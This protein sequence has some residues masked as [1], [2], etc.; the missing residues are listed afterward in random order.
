MTNGRGV[1]LVIDPIGGD[2]WKKSYLALRATGRL[3]M[4]GVST[5]SANGLKG[6]LGLLK[7]AWQT[8][9]FHPFGLMNKNKGVF[10]LNLGHMWDE[11]EKVAEWMKVIFD[12][13]KEGWIRPYVDK[14]FQFDKVAEAHTYIESRKNIG[15]VV[16]VP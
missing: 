7:A 10:G 2:H 11:Q 1:E 9:W 3:G 5:A 15:K 13:V 6:K 4:F 14:V 12:G 8:P 16:L